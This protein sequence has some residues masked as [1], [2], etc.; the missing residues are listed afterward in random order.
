MKDSQQRQLN[1]LEWVQRFM[2]ESAPDD[3]R[4][5]SLRKEIDEVVARLNANRDRQYMATRGLSVDGKTIRMMAAELREKT[6]LNIARHGKLLVRNQPRREEMLKVP[7]KRV[8]PEVMADY[9]LALAAWL[10]EF[11]TAFT[12]AGFKKDFLTELR[13]DAMALRRRSNPWSPGRV[14][15]GLPRCSGSDVPWMCAF[16]DPVDSSF[17]GAVS[18]ASDCTAAFSS[19]AGARGRSRGTTRAGRLSA[20]RSFSAA[21]RAAS[22]WARKRAACGRG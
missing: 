2:H 9:A 4:L 7:A 20:P 6:L 17:G 8:T 3:P 15:S 16:G 12:G 14:G 22:A 11:K 1:S 18:G 10:K 5:R 13:A 21:S 19:S